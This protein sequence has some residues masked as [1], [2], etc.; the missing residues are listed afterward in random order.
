MEEDTDGP[1]TKRDIKITN[2]QYFIIKPCSRKTVK[3]LIYFIL[4]QTPI[5]NSKYKVKCEGDERAM[6]LRSTWPSYYLRL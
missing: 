1:I 6:L 3:F 2:D 5:F 4:F